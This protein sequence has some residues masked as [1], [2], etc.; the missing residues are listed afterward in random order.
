MTLDQHIAELRAELAG[1]LFSKSE[2]SRVAAELGAALARRS[3]ENE[4]KASSGGLAEQKSA[5]R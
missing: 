4:E 3:R 1:C 2:R 5:A